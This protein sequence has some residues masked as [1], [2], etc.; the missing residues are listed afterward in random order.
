MQVAQILL[1]NYWETPEK[2]VAPPR[3]LDGNDLMRELKLEPGRIV[4]Q[5][6]EEI[7]EGQ[8]IG[9]IET[10]EQAIDFAREQLKH[11]EDS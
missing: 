2:T 3:L 10:R 7:R 6:L 11:L 5:L 9:S 4:G 8:A 1:K